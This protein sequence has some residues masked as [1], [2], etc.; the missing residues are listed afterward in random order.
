MRP[1]GSVISDRQRL[2]I[3]HAA[4][5]YFPLAVLGGLFGPGLRNFAGR[6]RYR[7]EILL[8]PGQRL[9]WIELARDDQHRVIG[10]VILAVESLQ[11]F[12]RHVLDIGAAADG[13][14]AV[15]MP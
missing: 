13:R 9:P 15:R 2:I 5:D 8:D 3:A 11:I 12:D 4:Q 1:R 10:L 7:S 14:P 6:F